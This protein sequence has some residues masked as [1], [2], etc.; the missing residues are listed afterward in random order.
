MGRRNTRIDQESEEGGHGSRSNA[1][2]DGWHMYM[3][4]VNNKKWSSKEPL[5]GLAHFILTQVLWTNVKSVKSSSAWMPV[6][7]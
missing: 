7:S 1:S 6:Y 5:M 3:G 2:D 4:F